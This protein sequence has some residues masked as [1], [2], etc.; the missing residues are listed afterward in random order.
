MADFELKV[1]NNPESLESI[2]D[3]DPMTT[4]IFGGETDTY[5]SVG[6]YYSFPPTEDTDNVV[7]EYT[8]KLETIG[9]DSCYEL[10]R[11]MYHEETIRGNKEEISSA[12]TALLTL[13]NALQ[14]QDYMK[15]ADIL[16]YN[17]DSIKS[18]IDK[19]QNI[20]SEV[21]N[22]SL[23][24]LKAIN[25]KQQYTEL[26]VKYNQLTDEVNTLR[27]GNVNSEELILTKE[28]LK[29]VNEKYASVLNELADLKAS[30]KN[31]HSHAEYEE[32]QGKLDLT[33]AQLKEA[34]SKQEKETNYFG[35]DADKDKDELI[36]ILKGQLAKAQQASGVNVDE[37][38]PIITNAVHLNANTLITLK[39]IR[40]APYLN[41]LIEWLKVRAISKRVIQNGTRALILVYDN[42]NEIDTIRYKKYH[43]AINEVPLPEV[44]VVVTNNLS[45]AFLRNVIGISKYNHI[46]VIDR[47][48]SCKIVTD[49]T[50]GK[51]FFLIDS[52]SNIIDYSLKAKNC[53]A[54]YDSKGECAI[55][56]VPDKELATMNKSQRLFSITTNDALKKIFD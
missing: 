43:Y 4:L 51:T 48:G 14:M 41:S 19:L 1:L 7:T 6:F 39:E 44:P 5:K 9:L 28:E 11:A 21:E 34:R 26:V 2:L 36:A 53:I 8:Q 25:L 52:P 20:Y 40:R 35:D 47:L 54:F 37:S 27:K 23:W 38:L 16:K 3:Y 18:V 56:V 50:D 31:M 32:L 24:E 13:V 29:E 45:Q 49:R 12:N 42:L 33:E 30:I 15:V 10:H 17:I 55:D 46:V 22:D